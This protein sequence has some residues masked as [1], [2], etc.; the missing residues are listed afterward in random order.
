[1]TTISDNRVV[2]GQITIEQ[3]L[4]GINLNMPLNPLAITT[5]GD[6]HCKAVP[7]ALA[8]TLLSLCGAPTT[9]N[10]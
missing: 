5:T 2:H 8:C 6:S 3:I 4:G 7:S 9:P 10:D 1:M